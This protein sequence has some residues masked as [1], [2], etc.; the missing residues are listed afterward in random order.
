MKTYAIGETAAG[1]LTY[2]DRKRAWWA[3]SV[4]MPMLPLLGIALSEATGSGRWLWFPIVFIYVCVPLLDW[5]VGVDPSNPPQAAVVA[6]EQDRYFARLLYLVVPLHLTVFVAGM[7]YAMNVAGSFPE[8]LAVVLSLGFAAALSINSGHELGHKAPAADRAL[9]LLALA[10]PGYGHFRIEHNLGH[11]VQ[12]ATPGDSASARMGESVYR[13]ALRELPGGML[14][15]WRIEARRLARAGKRPW[16]MHNEILQAHAMTALLQ[17]GLLAWLGW[18][19]LPWLLLHNLWAWLQVTGINYIEHYGLL[20]QQRAGG[21]YERC[22]P[23]HSWNSNHTVSNLMLFHLQR[24]SDHHAHAERS[25]QSLRH[26]EETPQLPT[27]YMGM[28]VLS[29]LPQL[30][31]R[32]MDPRLLELVGNDLAQVNMRPALRP[33]APT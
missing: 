12:V 27:G 22:L 9:A 2:T 10:I 15:G 3:L 4:L 28:L 16:S 30:F 26:F 14:R 18:R 11:H 21:G 19:A 25:Y 33:A 31:F 24:H 8:R 13:F 23:R 32:V 1:P 29:Y 5:A 6:L 17:G 20:R 7:A